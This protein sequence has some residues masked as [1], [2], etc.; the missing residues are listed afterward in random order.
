M[1]N[2]TDCWVHMQTRGLEVIRLC[3]GGPR[4]LR[5]GKVVTRKV[6]Y[7]WC[8]KEQKHQYCTVFSK[9][10]TLLPSPCVQVPPLLWQPCCLHAQRNILPKRQQVEVQWYLAYFLITYIFSILYVLSLHINPPK[11]LVIYIAIFVNND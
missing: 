9:L 10:K 7:N 8:R 4:L 1:K 3:K 11:L 5:Q 2:G 6:M